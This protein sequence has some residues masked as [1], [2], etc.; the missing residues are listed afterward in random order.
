MEDLKN[1]RSVVTHAEI[2]R[3]EKL[4]KVRE[5]DKILRGIDMVQEFDDGLFGVLV[6]RV[7]VLNMVQVEFVLR[8]SVEVVELV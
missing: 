4:D 5:I 1:R 6:D 2:A 3:R 7:K 8:A